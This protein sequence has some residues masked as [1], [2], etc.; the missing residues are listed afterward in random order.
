MLSSYTSI[1]YACNERKFRY[2][3]LKWL[4]V[5]KFKVKFKLL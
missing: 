4:L 2:I 5:V 1:D 3:S